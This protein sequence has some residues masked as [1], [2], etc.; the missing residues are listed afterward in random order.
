[1]VEAKIP[2][3]QHNRYRN[4]TH[5]RHDSADGSDVPSQLFVSEGFYCK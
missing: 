4:H 2:E 3:H 5:L 1:V